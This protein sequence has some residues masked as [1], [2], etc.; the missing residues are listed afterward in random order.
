[1]EASRRT[2]TTGHA[3]QLKV[4]VT[5]VALL[6]VFKQHQHCYLQVD[7]L[8]AQTVGLAVEKQELVDVDVLVLE[9]MLE[10][11]LAVETHVLVGQVDC[12]ALDVLRLL[13]SH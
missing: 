13:S 11:F 9:L 1:M 8:P 5:Q 6:A 2:R 4:V 7:L 12:L 3:C 10:N